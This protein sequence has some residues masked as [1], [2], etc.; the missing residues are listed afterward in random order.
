MSSLMFA[1]H[2]R[3]AAREDRLSFD[4]HFNTNITQ[5]L[6]TLEQ[7]CLSRGVSSAPSASSSRVR[8]VCESEC[9]FYE[10]N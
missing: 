7:S 2:K 4:H 5:T 1:Q 6:E 10:A 8:G 9:S 3:K